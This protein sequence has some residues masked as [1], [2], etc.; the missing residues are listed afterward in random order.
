MGFS[1][2]FF[3]FGFLPIFMLLYY[4]VPSRMRNVVLLIGSMFF[5][6]WGEPIYLILMLFSSIFHY[7]MGLEIESLR[8]NFRKTKLN[9]I[10]VIV[11]D[12]F[13]LGFFKYYGFLMDTIG[14]IFRISISYPELS[15]PI[16][17]S[18]YTFKNLSYIFDIYKKE[19]PAEKNFLHFAVYTTMFP[20]MSAGPIVR[21][22]DVSERLAKRKLNMYNFGVGAEYFIKGLAKK[23]ILADNLAAIY[24][25]IFA[26]TT[27]N[28][29]LSSWIGIFAY[30]MQIYF[31]FSGY[32][33]MAIGLGQMLGFRFKKNF[34]Y[35][36]ISTSVSE[37]WRRWHMSLGSWFRDYI[38]IPLGGNR[39]STRC[40]IRNILVV[41][42]LTGL[43]H[44]ASW[45][46]V[47]W[48]VYY[49]I[50][51]LIEKFLLKDFLEKKLPKWACNLYTMFAV[52]IGWVF[53]SQTN[54]SSMGKYLLSLIG[55]GTS[56]L[57]DVAALHYL[58]SGFILFI[59]S[60]IACRP[61]LYKL[62]KHS[63]KHRPWLAIGFNIVLFVISVSYMVYNSYTPFLYIQF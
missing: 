43:W 20:H 14:G 6:A 35:P 1:S 18:F 55:I 48:G 34:D 4:L 19:T 41:W 42:A 32:S 39:V 40:Q 56:G 27:P 17:L 30:T 50:L 60:I 63:M 15:L 53:F 5:Y 54:F 9:L 51:L 57:I 7:I 8:F 36:Y 58:R 29:M 33:D 11:V 59:I 3:V 16:G 12:I 22:S 49:G 52:M 47:F 13:I 37:F 62:C 10:F 61:G 45:N 23:I 28:S 38:Y 44:G 31:D 25:D 24:M 46:F 26:A 2:I 21:Y